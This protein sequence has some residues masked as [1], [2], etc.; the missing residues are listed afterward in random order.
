MDIIDKILQVVPWRFVHVVYLDYHFGTRYSYKWY[1]THQ[2]V[3]PQVILNFKWSSS[4]T[5]SL[6]Y[7]SSSLSIGW[8]MLWHR[9]RCPANW[10]QG[11]RSYMRYL[12]GYK[13][14]HSNICGGVHKKYKIQISTIYP[15]AILCINKKH[16][17]YGN[18]WQRRRSWNKDMKMHRGEK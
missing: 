4:E 7:K 5:S 13:W 1:L 9:G 3:V 8:P 14:C 11:Q 18:W 10:Y 15:N 2:M 12:K 16:I 17:F 6:T